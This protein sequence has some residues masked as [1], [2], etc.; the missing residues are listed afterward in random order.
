MPHG[1]IRTQI[2]LH[3]IRAFHN[4]VETSEKDGSHHCQSLLCC[5]G[6]CVCACVCV[7]VCVCEGVFI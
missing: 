4:L 3:L 2:Q 7:C 5:S 1:R 6:V